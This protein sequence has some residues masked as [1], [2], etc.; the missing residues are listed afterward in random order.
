MRMHPLLT[1]AGLLL[2]TLG[3]FVPAAAL[4]DSPQQ[5]LRTEAPSH[6]FFR[7]SIYPAW[8]RMSPQQAMTDLHAAMAQTRTRLENIA[9]LPAEQCNFS[10]TFLAYTEASENLNQVQIYLEFLTNNAETPELVQLR[11]IVVREYAEFKQNL[12]VLSRVWPVLHAA[13]ES[14]WAKALPATHQRVIQSVMRD[15][16]HTGIH[17][18]PKQRA[19]KA[20]IEQELQFL[21]FQFSHNLNADTASRHLLITDPAQLDG[22]P[23]TWMQRAAKAAHAAGHGSEATPAWLINLSGAHADAVLHHCT[24]QKTRR[25]AW[26]LIHSAGTAMA[27]DNE[28][29][30]YRIMELRHELATMLGYKHY[31]DMKTADRMMRSGENALAFV[32]DMLRQS[33]PAWDAWV[34]KKLHRFSEAAGKQLTEIAPWD[35]KFILSHRRDKPTANAAPSF[36]EAELTPYLELNNVLSGMLRLWSDLLGVTYTEIPTARLRPGESCP[37]GHVETWAPNIRC[38][39]VRDTQSGKH[40]GSFFL[41]I[42]PRP[43]KRTD[44]TYCFPLRTADPGEP[45]IAAMVANFPQAAPG[46]PGLLSLLHLRML[47]HEFGHLM[48]MCLAEPPLRPLAAMNVEIDFVETPS[49]LQERWIWEP[50]AITGFAR[51][52]QTGAPIPPQLLQQLSSAGAAASITQHISMLLSAKLDLEL[53]MHFHEKF[54]G[55]PLDEATAELLRPWLFPGAENT[56]SPFRTLTHCIVAGYDAGFYTYKWSEVLAADAF[57]R[58]RQEGLLNPATGAD[59]RR[60]ILTPGAT[61]PAE[62]LFRN[63]MGRDPN[64][65]PLLRRYLPDTKTDETPQP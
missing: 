9:A 37:A 55:R 1:T 63:F 39:E 13:A 30:I 28:P 45:T 43:G 34:A 5:D 15:L 2:L 42:F 62:Q 18:T 35:E 48:H 54:S 21:S 20:L 14:D 44:L 47:F 27:Q 56:P 3:G 6:P 8:S 19:R 4:S 12:E 58:F 59:Y 50:E 10:N 16:K 57:S 64:P 51:H 38:F 61:Q 40:L 33:K 25:D 53:H 32:N 31:A 24:V 52:H 23:D 29:V 11:N 26:L 60:T 41:D 49:H 17:L 7:D 46:N 36:N 22:M 65:T